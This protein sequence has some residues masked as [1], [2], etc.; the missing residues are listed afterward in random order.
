MDSPDISLVSGPVNGTRGHPWAAMRSFAYAPGV[1]GVSRQVGHR[2]RDLVLA[3][4]VWQHANVT[5]FGVIIIA[6]R[7]G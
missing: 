5:N 2:A 7:V 6:E 1:S 4:G 3:D